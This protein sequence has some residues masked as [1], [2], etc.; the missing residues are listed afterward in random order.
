MK[1]SYAGI[2]LIIFAFVGIVLAIISGRST[3][4]FADN[5]FPQD[6]G[7]LQFGY[8]AAFDIGML[9]W[10]LAFLY[11]AEGGLQRGLAALM[12]VA[13]F[14]ANANIF[15]LNQQMFAGIAASPSAEEILWAQ[16]L[17]T[18]AVFGHSGA[19][20]LFSIFSPKTRRQMEEQG[21]LDEIEEK[22]LENLKENTPRIAQQL[23]AIRGKAMLEQAEARA[24]LSTGLIIDSTS[25][26]TR[27]TFTPIVATQPA[28]HPSK[29]LRSLVRDKLTDLL[30]LK[31]PSAAEPD[32]PHVIDVDEIL[33]NPDM[34][35]QMRVALGM[36]Q[37]TAPPQ[38]E[39]ASN[40][41]SPNA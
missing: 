40:G 14:I 9:A 22:A 37:P 6:T 12:T 11:F 26:V 33:R 15:L 24:N 27:E 25:S 13:A 18:L 20:I 39:V 17:L 30:D 32:V 4:N 34:A 19:A 8:L 36:A 1:R 10:L 31:Q 2:A 16:Q 38:P 5:M 29:G 35:E 28:H 7:L 23:G 3:W 41:A 21:V